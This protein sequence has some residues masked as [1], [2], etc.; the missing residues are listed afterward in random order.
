MG[1]CLDLGGVLCEF[2]DAPGLAVEA[3]DPP[4]RLVDVAGRLR[5]V[6]DSLELNVARARLPASA[7]R[8]ARGVVTWPHGTILYDLQLRADSATLRDFPFIDRRLAPRARPGGLS[9][10]RRPAPPRP[11]PA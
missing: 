9:G 3:S 7:L 5:V 1:R 6:G 11:R 4:V 2:T 10:A 8:D